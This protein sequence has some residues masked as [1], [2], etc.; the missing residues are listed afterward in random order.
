MFASLQALFHFCCSRWK[1]TGSSAVFWHHHSPVSFPLFSAAYEGVKYFSFSTD[2]IALVHV[3]LPLVFAL[4]STV[5][6]SKPSHLIMWPICLCSCCRIEYNICL[7]SM[8]S[9]FHSLLVD[10]FI[11]IADPLQRN[12]QAD[13]TMWFLARCLSSSLRRF[14]SGKLL[15]DM[16]LRGAITGKI[17]RFNKTDSCSSRFPVLLQLVVEKLH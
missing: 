17:G 2:H 13:R 5:S 10:V 16:A 3:S 15:G 4:H 9:F 7:S 14:F 1:N 6:C 12:L 8:F 11:Y